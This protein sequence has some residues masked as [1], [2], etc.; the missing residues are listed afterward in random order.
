M[1]SMDVFTLIL[2]AFFGGLIFFGF[3]VHLLPIIGLRM[4]SFKSMSRLMLA[5]LFVMYISMA[6]PI[7]AD[8]IID[9]RDIFHN[10]V[11]TTVF[12]S[13]WS[14]AGISHFVYDRSKRCRRR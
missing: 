10:F 4:P 2:P 5:I 6:G 3:L 11:F 13:F 8:R 1:I 12:V 14:G 9:G 7:Y